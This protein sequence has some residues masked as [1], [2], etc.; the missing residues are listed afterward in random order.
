MEAL[1]IGEDDFF[2]FPGPHNL[3]NSISKD[4]LRGAVGEQTLELA[5]REPARQVYRQEQQP[6]WVLF[7]AFLET[8]QP[9]AIFKKKE[10]KKTATKD[11]SAV[12]VLSLTD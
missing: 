10:H 8:E 6:C 1:T 9:A 4:D 5:V 2:I 3:T 7:V 11:S 12:R